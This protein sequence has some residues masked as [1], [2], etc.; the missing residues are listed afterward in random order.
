M[1]NSTTHGLV[2][3]AVKQIMDRVWIEEISEGIHDIVI[4][5]LVS[6]LFLKVLS[7]VYPD[8]VE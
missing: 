3:A 5:D 7:R 8:W 4:R 6:C 1:T 2:K